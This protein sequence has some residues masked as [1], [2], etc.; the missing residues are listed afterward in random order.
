MVFALT[1]RSLTSTLLPTSTI[2]ILSQTRT[3]SEIE[4]AD[5]D[6]WDWDYYS[7]NV[8]TAVPIRDILVGDS[9]GDVEHDDGALP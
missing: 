4:T 2:G 8:L 1:L 7:L 9:R 5:D 6:R 3:R